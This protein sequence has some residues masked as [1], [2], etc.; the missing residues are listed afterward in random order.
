MAIND[1]PSI[2]T[3]GMHVTVDGVHI[4]T[5]AGLPGLNSGSAPDIPIT[6]GRSLAQEFRKGFR[7]PGS[8]SIPLILVPQSAIHTT[9]SK[10][11]NEG[12]QHTVVFRGGGTLDAKTGYVTNMAEVVDADLGSYSHTH[13]G[14]EATITFAALASA[15]PAVSDGDYI[16]IDGSD[17]KVNSAEFGTNDVGVIKVAA[18]A[19][20]TDYDAGVTV[21]KLLRPGFRVT[22]TGSIEQFSYDGAVDD[23]WRGTVVIRLSGAPAEV[24]GSPD[25]S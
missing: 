6:T 21:A 8:V 5:A 13:A 22:Y 20:V 14:Q 25:L 16:E 24:V 10:A 2:S 7:D 18:S 23:V 4:A 11:A 1:T 9:L 15:M 19:D 3:R 17:Y 12:T